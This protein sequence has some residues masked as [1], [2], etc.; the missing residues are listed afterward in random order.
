MNQHRLELPGDLAVA[1]PTDA[2]LDQRKRDIVQY[3]ISMQESSNTMSAVEY[4]KAR[5]V[6]P[7]VIER[8]LEPRRRRNPE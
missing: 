5:G 4:L 6:A 8:V 3:G 2:R 1:A 7:H